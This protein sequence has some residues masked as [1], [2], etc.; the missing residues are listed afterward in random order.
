MS[1]FPPKNLTYRIEIHDP[2]QHNPKQPGKRTP[3]LGH[4]R[5]IFGPN[6][7]TDLTIQEA[8]ETITLLLQRDRF[9]DARSL[10]NAWFVSLAHTYG[11]NHI[12]LGPT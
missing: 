12:S 8:L 4:I 5:V 10:A 7:Y 6:D 2:A 11:H 3:D 1:T 9:D